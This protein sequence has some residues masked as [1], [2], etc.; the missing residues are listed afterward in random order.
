MVTNEQPGEP[1]ASLLVQHWAKQT[2]AIFLFSTWYSNKK[3]GLTS[4]AAFSGSLKVASDDPRQTSAGNMKC[5][6]SI[7]ET[8]EF[9][10]QKT[11]CRSLFSSSWKRSFE[12]AGGKVWATKSQFKP[13]INVCWFY[14]HVLYICIATC[15]VRKKFLDNKCS[16]TYWSQ[17]QAFDR[18]LWARDLRER[19]R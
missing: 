12:A 5:K 14:I 7:S 13:S 8:G 16:L 19:R 10:V 9:K 6:S 1:R 17:G 2:F 3:Y 18:M 4:S 11:C 15:H